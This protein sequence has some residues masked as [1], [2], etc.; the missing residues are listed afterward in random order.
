LPFVGKRLALPLPVPFPDSGGRAM[1]P[2]VALR[3]VSR[4]FAEQWRATT[5]T[6]RSQ[7]VA[8]LCVIMIAFYGVAI[9]P[10]GHNKL[11]DL[12]Y[13]ESKLKARQKASGKGAAAQPAAGDL[14]ITRARTEL[15]RAQESLDAL[16]AERTRLSERFIAL[17]DLDGLQSLKSELTRLAEAGGM[18][19]VALE[20]MGGPPT[21]ELLKTASQGN[22]YKRPLLLLKA[23]VRYHGLLRFLDGLQTLSRTAAPVWSSI[24]V[25]KEGKVSSGPPLLDVEIRLAI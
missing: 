21:L 6:Q 5:V 25:N 14:D 13:K 17:E 3:N 20:H 11:Q 1:T 24:S 15:G 2:R 16:Q 8:G 4:K 19:I 18:E 22:P 12:L 7:F 10:A 23:R 9:W